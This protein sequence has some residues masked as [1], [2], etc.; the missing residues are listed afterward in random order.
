MRLICALLAALALAGCTKPVPPTEESRAVAEGLEQLCA[1]Y[2]Q[3]GSTRKIEVYD[4]K[5]KALGWEVDN[6]P[7]IYM[8]EKEG[9][10]GRVRIAFGADFKGA[11]T[12]RG[13]AARD[14]KV[15]NSAAVAA[16]IQAWTQKA[17]PEAR[18][19][20]NRVAAEAP[21]GALRSEWLGGGWSIVLKELPVEGGRP[22]TQVDVKRGFY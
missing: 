20:K 7:G 19:E 1:M 5:M 9:A 2:L 12:I 22:V 6:P 14:E 10:W 17:A 21:P 18:R 8:F 15:H 3:P 16:A 13:W 11:C 4:A